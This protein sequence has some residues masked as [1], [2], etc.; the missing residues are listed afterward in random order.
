MA[1]VDYASQDVELWPDTAWRLREVILTDQVAG[2]LNVEHELPAETDRVRYAAAFAKFEQWADAQGLRS[3]PASGYVVAAHLLDLL[4]AGAALDVIATSA[5][6]IK[7]HHEKAQEY[8][9]WPPVRAAL[10]FALELSGDN[11]KTKEEAK[12]GR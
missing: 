8:L 12:H 4:F 1:Y 6:A 10:D 11:S 5:A 7:F 2:M 3:L 9:H